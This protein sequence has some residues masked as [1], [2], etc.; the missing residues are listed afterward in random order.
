VR[1]VLELDGPAAAG[2]ELRGRVSIAE[3]GEHRGLQVAIR[4][5]EHSRD[6][7]EEVVYAHAVLAHEGE[8]TPDDAFPFALTVPRQAGPPIATEWGGLAWEVR[9][10][11]DVALEHDPQVSQPLPLA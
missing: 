4:L 6:Y 5:C 2:D 10:W 3:G 7:H 1:L 11:A 9:A 8:L